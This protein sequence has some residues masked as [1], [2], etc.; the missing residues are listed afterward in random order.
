MKRCN[1][2]DGLHTSMMRLMLLEHLDKA[3]L[4]V[5]HNIILFDNPA[6][7]EVRMETKCN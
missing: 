4:L 1:N 5:G 3:T 6:L 2:D 7:E